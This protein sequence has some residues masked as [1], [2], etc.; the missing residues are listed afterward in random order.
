MAMMKKR[1][2]AV[3][4]LGVWIAALGSAA[5]LTYNANRPTQV[6]GGGGSQ[7]DAPSDMV[8]GAPFASVPGQEMESV[9]YMPDVTIVGKAPHARLGPRR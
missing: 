6:A 2:M 5:A 1:M 3:I 7:A 8:G 9:L 4:T